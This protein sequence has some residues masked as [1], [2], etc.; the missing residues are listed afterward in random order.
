MPI[1]CVLVPHFAL[2]VALHGQPD[3][4]GLPVALGSPP[5]SRPIVTD[6]SPEAA[7]SG[8]RPGMA[9]RKALGVVPELIVIPPDPAREVAMRERITAALL[10]FSPLVEEA[11]APGGWY[12]D[13]VGSERALKHLSEAA[14]QLE[15]AVPAELR[16]AR[17]GI[18]PGKFAARIAARR[19]RPGRPR[20]IAPAEVPAAIA[21]EPSAALP[22][23]FDTLTLLGQLGLGTLGDVA[24]LAPSAIAARLGPAGRRAWLLASGQSDDEDRT[25]R[26]HPR[27]TVVTEV[28]DLP[29]P[30]A[31]RD[32]LLV[33][34]GVLVQR[35]FTR[36]ALRDRYAR[37]IQL[38][39]QLDRDPAWV[40][41]AVFREALSAAPMI[42]ALGLRL[43]AVEIAGS[44]ESLT[45]RLS[46]LTGTTGRQERLPGLRGHDDRPLTAAADHLERRY[47]EPM[48]FRVVEV[49]PWSRIPERRHALAPYAP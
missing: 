38:R 35:A 48:L 26:P 46:G 9:V 2:Q 14:H 13:L 11:A 25:V 8:I 32:A 44:V 30:T 24:A 22:L 4:D 5:G 37:R 10:D 49:E 1:A 45:L 39:A 34:L 16:S 43:G 3:L 27:E 33:V 15:A 17:A 29:A 18:A 19:S 47:G 21:R 41:G 36:P 7:G 40:W 6:V 28:L 12:V 42:T 23:P 20:I 31:S